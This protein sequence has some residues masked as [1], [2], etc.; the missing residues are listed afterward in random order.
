MTTQEI[1]TE[2][3]RLNKELD[4]LMMDATFDEINKEEIDKLRE[5]KILIGEF[6]YNQVHGIVERRN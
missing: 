3:R 5:A 2:A 4:S 1:T 6:I